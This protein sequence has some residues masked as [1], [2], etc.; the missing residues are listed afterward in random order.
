M[1][2][3]RGEG[4]RPP[5]TRGKVEV[6]GDCSHLPNSRIQSGEQSDEEY[7][8]LSRRE[9]RSLALS[10]MTNV[11]RDET[12]LPTH[13]SATYDYNNSLRPGLGF[14]SLPLV[15]LDTGEISEKAH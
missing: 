3:R 13:S 6:F 12:G 5:V 15:N 9:L 2:R 10:G 14:A 8:F 4:A 1:L 11:G 7:A